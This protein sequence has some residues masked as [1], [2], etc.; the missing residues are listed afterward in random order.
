M[1]VKNMSHTGIFPSPTCCYSSRASGCAWRNP[2]SR[3]RL[4]VG[5]TTISVAA[6]LSL[7]LLAFPEGGPQ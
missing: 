2:T 6:E 4:R 5:V 1:E 7:S 3:L